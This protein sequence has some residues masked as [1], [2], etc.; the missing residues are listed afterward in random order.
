MLIKGGGACLKHA[1]GSM[2]PA[3]PVQIGQGSA[4]P[5]TV[6]LAW[7]LQCPPPRGGWRRSCP[8]SQPLRPRPMPM[9]PERLHNSQHQRESFCFLLAV[10]CLWEA[11]A[12]LFAIS[13]S[14]VQHPTDWLS[15][16]LQA[17]EALRGLQK[18]CGVLRKVLTQG[19]TRLLKGF[20]RDGARC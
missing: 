10:P 17:G 16:I 8:L 6:H 5:G 3:R 12:L 18:P 13:A 4:Q 1:W 14:A 2:C 11:Q 9:R 19:Y 15:E 7:P 20:T